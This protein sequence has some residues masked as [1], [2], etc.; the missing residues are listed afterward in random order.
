MELCYCSVGQPDVVID[1]DQFGDCS[2]KLSLLA[3]KKI[4]FTNSV[5]REPNVHVNADLLSGCWIFTHYWCNFVYIYI[6]SARKIQ[7]TNS[8]ITEPI[9]QAS[10]DQFR[11]RWIF[12]Y[13]LWNF[14]YTFKIIFSI[15]YWIF[16]RYITAVEEN[17]TF[18]LLTVN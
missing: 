18:T 4:H 1:M 7:F 17:A 13:H 16:G 15:S 5:I 6:Y 8:V 10:D 14:V 11:V 3:Q 9:V 2:W 12:T